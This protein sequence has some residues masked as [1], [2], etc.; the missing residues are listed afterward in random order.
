[1]PDVKIVLPEY[2]IAADK[3]D[4]THEFTVAS[5]VNEARWVRAAD[6]LPGTPSVV[7][8]AIIAVKGASDS[9]FAPEQVLGRWLPGQEPE[10]ID[11]DGAVYKLPANAELTVRVHYKKNWQFEGKPMKDMSTVGLYF[12][13]EKNAQELLA[14]P[15]AAPASA[16]PSDQKLTF[17]QTIDQDV[18]ALAVS[19]IEVPPNI[20][21]QAEAVL[22]RSKS[23]CRAARRS[24]WSRS[25][26]IRICSRP[27]SASPDRRSRRRRRCPCGSP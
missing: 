13:A 12:A 16:A 21:L 2:E 11:R 24:R 19:P 10:S 18:Q 17:T 14:V 5:G 3:M 26:R 7:R 22:P 15:V 9:A 8:S 6:L 27:R 23:R 20:T 1:L 25:C 4:D